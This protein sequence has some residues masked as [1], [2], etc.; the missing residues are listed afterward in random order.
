MMN[1]STTAKY[2]DLE[3]SAYADI[4]PEAIVTIEEGFVASADGCEEDY[5]YAETAEEAAED[6]VSSGDW[7]DNDGKT[8]WVD[9]D[10]WRRGTVLDEDG[11]EVELKIDEKSHS[12]AVEPDEPECES[13]EGCHEWESP[14]EVLGGIEENPGCWGHGG[15]VVIREVCR[16][17]GMYREKD[18]WAQ[19]PNTGA[20]G[21]TSVEYEPADESSLDWVAKEQGGDEED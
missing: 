19:D 6:Y 10:T 14:F 7:G 3:T 1:M 11:D 2:K 13:D 15:G 16:H 4:S 18:T 21:L 8:F 12:I 17:C 20:Q 5:P 9:V